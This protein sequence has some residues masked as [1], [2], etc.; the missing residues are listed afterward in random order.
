MRSLTSFIVTP[1]NDTR[2]NHTSESGIVLSV[3]QEDHTTTNRMA[4]IVSLPLNYT[5][6]AVVGDILLVHHN[7]FRKYYAMNGK[8]KSGPAHF[9]D[10]LYFIFADQ[11][12]MYQHD[13][14]WHAPSPYIFVKPTDD[15]LVGIVKYT[16]SDSSV[17]VGDRVLFEPESEYEF[18]VDGETLY[19]M[20]NRNMVVKL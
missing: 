12:Y 18:K 14:I 5:G 7:T 15:K 11:Y 19:R 13:G 10:N 4:T 2:Y 8:E 9:R 6:G 17:N 20:F 1:L 16:N 3:S